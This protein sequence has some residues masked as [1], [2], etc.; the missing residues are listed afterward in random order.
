MKYFRNAELMA[1]LNSQID[2]QQSR[3]TRSDLANQR[4]HEILSEITNTIYKLYE[5]FQVRIIN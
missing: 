1:Q 4:V 5:K 3:V 2:E